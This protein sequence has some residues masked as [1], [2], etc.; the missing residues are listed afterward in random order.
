MLATAHATGFDLSLRVGCPEHYLPAFIPSFVSFALSLIM[1]AHYYNLIFICAF[2]I[3][4]QAA[5]E[6]APAPAPAEAVEAV[7]LP[8]GSEMT[9]QVRILLKKLKARAQNEARVLQVLACSL[10]KQFA[11][12]VRVWFVRSAKK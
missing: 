11:V 8:P 7:A 1:N 12:D 5:P 9:K 3:S 2:Q 6:E 4:V 10:S